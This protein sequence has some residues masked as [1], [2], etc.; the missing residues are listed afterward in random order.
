VVHDAPYHG[1]GYGGGFCMWVGKG[2]RVDIEVNIV[3][4][5]VA[6]RVVFF[7]LGCGGLIGGK[8]ETTNVDKEDMGKDDIF[9]LTLCHHC[10]MFLKPCMYVCFL[11]LFFLRNRDHFAPFADQILVHE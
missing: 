9:P 4:M 10:C 11:R 3:S 8:D 5:M 2:K 6:S 7:S 1:S